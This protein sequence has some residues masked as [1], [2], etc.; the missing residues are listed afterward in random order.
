[1]KFVDYVDKKK[2]ERRRSLHNNIKVSYQIRSISPLFENSKQYAMLIYADM[3][4]YVAYIQV[5]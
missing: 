5:E 4:E 3:F 2:R 1:M